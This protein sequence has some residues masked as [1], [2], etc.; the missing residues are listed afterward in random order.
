MLLSKCRFLLL[1]LLFLPICTLADGYDEG[2]SALVSKDY[3]Q[4]R[5]YML[6]AAAQG[7]RGA[8]YELWRL[9]QNGWGGA[10]DSAQALQWLLVAAYLGLP[11]A[12]Y[13]LAE[14]YAERKDIAHAEEH[15]LYWWKA[16]ASESHPLAYYR[17]GQAYETGIGTKP[18]FNQAQA[19]Y[20]QA[21][22]YLQIH[23][24]K[25]NPEAQFYVASCYEQGHGVR[26]NWDTALAW[27]KK[28][29]SNGYT[30]GL[31]HSGRL[32]LLQAKNE[33][34]LQQAAYWLNLAKASGSELASSLLNEI[35]SRD[36]QKAV[37]TR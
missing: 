30:P 29:G 22:N 37:V 33:A 31:T 12:Q 10:R 15:A 8:A 11:Q 27:Y 7:D 9:Y 20:S 4:A 28:A 1:S 34:Q 2:L 24:E 36:R 32:L 25:G 23:A 6:E 18:D 35:E 26:Q 19:Y 17:L 16:A 21:M 14:Q 3:S 5:Q 13:E